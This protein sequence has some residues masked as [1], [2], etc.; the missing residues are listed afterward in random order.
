MIQMYF[1]AAAIVVLS[2]LIFWIPRNATPQRFAV[3]I[4]TIIN[5]TVIMNGI[6]AR[7][8]KVGFSGLGLGLGFAG[9]WIKKL[10][11]V[12]TKSLYY[13]HIR[14]YLQRVKH[15]RLLSPAFMTFSLL[16][17]SRSL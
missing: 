9:G 8:P 16:R 7:L 5:M 1:P 14:V 12:F 4:T 2:W 13:V 6:N 17:E 15:Q 10:I 3:G 11:Y